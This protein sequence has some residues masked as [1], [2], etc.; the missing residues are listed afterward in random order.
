MDW[1]L[2]AATTMPATSSGLV[3]GKILQV[4]ADIDVNVHLAV[5]G[6]GAEPLIQPGQVDGCVP[7]HAF[8]V[9]NEPAKTCQGDDGHL[10]SLQE[11]TAQAP[12]TRAAAAIWMPA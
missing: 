10:A 1:P 6:G 5:V 3:I 2:Y 12:I 4:E 7:W 8:E 11:Y 9:R